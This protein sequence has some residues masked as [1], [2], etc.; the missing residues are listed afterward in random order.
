MPF[1]SI[2]GVTLHHR[3]IEATGTSRPIIFIN[4]LGTDFRIWDDI[5]AQLAGEMP[6]L[7]YDKRGHGLS[8]IG[9]GVRSIDD[10]VDDLS[11]LID[12][13]GLDKVVLCGLSVGGMVAQRLHARRPEIV[14]ALILSDTAHKIGTAESWNA[15]IATLERDGIEAIAD[16]IMKVWFTPDFHTNRAAELAG[17][18]NMLTRQALPGYIGT[19]MAVRDADFTDSAR[20]IAAPTLC[21]VGDRDGSTPPDLVRSFSELI[22]GARF[23]VIRGAGHIPCIEQPDALANL[24]RDFVASLPEGKHAHG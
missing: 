9:G 8:D 11:A 19:C 15:R 13:F 22:P 2:G 10:H 23:E 16:G 7:V 14:E 17:C 12:H 24:I 1:V 4:S 5:V 20:R 18:R 6:M 21:I 3:A